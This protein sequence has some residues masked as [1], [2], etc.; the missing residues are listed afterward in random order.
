V[1]LVLERARTTLYA[2][3]AQRVWPGCDDKVLAGWNGLMLRALVE[4]ARVFGSESARTLALRNAAFLRD[5]LVREG[6]ALRSWREGKTQSVGF[7]EDQ[8]SV[9]LAFLD[10]F[11]L[12]SDHAWLDLAREMTRE[13]VENFHDPA[14]LFFDTPR[15]HEALI[16]RPRDVTD[17]ALPAGS[18]LMAELLLRVAIIDDQADLRTLGEAI[19]HSLADAM[20]QYPAGFGHLLAAADLIV[21]GAVE[22]A[23]TGD[24]SSSERTALERA[25]GRRY[26]PSLVWATSGSAGDPETA[27]T[28]GKWDERGPTAYVCR[29]YVCSAPTSDP[30]ALIEQLALAVMQAQA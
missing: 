30:T 27:L 12:T 2:A 25:L 10:V 28:R 9:A 18:S 1:E 4:V 29:R 5:T 8:A 21:H 20:G 17:N 22:V 15:D 6:R 7:L 14:G 24:A 16:T 3:R 23:I 11:S 19:V 26:V 13:A